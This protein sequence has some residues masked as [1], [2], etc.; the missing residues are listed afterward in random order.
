MLLCI[1]ETIDDIEK[2]LHGK[3]NFKEDLV[4]KLNEVMLRTT[5]QK[6]KLQESIYKFKQRMASEI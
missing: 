1:L 2:I 6:G 4:E 3:R 5:E